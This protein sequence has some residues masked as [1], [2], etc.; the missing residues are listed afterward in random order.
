MG[1]RHIYSSFAHSND[2]PSL[3]VVLHALKSPLAH[4]HK[5]ELVFVVTHQVRVVSNGDQGDV[6]FLGL[7]KDLVL[8]FYADGAGAFIKNTILWTRSM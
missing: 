2:F 5:D 3:F 1:G 8:H 6:K 4:A 7:L